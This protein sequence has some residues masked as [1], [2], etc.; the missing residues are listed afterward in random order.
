MRQANLQ[1][2]SASAGLSSKSDAVPGPARSAGIT[3]NG[4]YFRHLQGGLGLVRGG[5]RQCQYNGGQRRKRYCCVPK[6]KSAGESAQASESVGC[7]YARARGTV[8][9]RVVG[10][11]GV[12]GIRVRWIGKRLIGVVARLC[13]NQA[14][15]WIQG[16]LSFVVERSKDIVDVSMAISI[17]VHKVFTSA[18]DLARVGLVRRCLSSPIKCRTGKLS[19]ISLFLV[20][21]LVSHISH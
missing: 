5:R 19:W 1:S 8:L 21:P 10:V 6:A 17:Q 4:P 15:V 14:T 16:C 3:S 18:G 11:V 13:V 9:G 12:T 2:G 7:N 20:I